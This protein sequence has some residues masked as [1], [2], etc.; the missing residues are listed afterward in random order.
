MESVVTLWPPEVFDAGLRM[1]HLL[2]KLPVAMKIDQHLKTPSLGVAK[3]RPRRWI[4][5][6]TDQSLDPVWEID[7]FV[8]QI[9]VNMTRRRYRPL[10]LDTN[11]LRTLY[12][13]QILSVIHLR[14]QTVGSWVK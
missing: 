7:T 11:P 14:Q 10:W 2:R 8:K 9:R 13:H 1:K 6:H 12:K 5:R 3:F 4:N